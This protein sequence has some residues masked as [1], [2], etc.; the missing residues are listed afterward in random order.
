MRFLR[1]KSKPKPVLVEPFHGD[2]EGW[3]V[4][5]LAMVGP[6]PYLV[7]YGSDWR[8]FENFDEAWAFHV[9]RGSTQYRSRLLCRSAAGAA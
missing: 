4:V 5:S 8:E 1:R 7:G 9:M 2:P 3:D 6:G